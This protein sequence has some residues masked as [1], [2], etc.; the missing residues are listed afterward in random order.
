M[1]KLSSITLHSGQLKVDI[2]VPSNVKLHPAEQTGPV[3]A[4][5]LLRRAMKTPLG[6]PPIEECAVGGDRIVVIVDPETPELP[7]I[8]TE[9]L[10]RLQQIGQGAVT[11]RLL[12]PADP[13]GQQ[14]NRLTATVPEE[15]RQSLIVDIH[16]PADEHQRG[17][18][19]SSAGGE[20]IYLN[21]HLLDA[22][23]IVM[24]STIQFDG[25]LGYRGTCSAVFPAFSDA[26]TIRETRLQGHPELTPDQ[27][28]PMRE[29]VDEIGW[30]LGT[31]FAVQVVPGAD[32]GV[33][34]I[35]AGAPRDVQHASQEQLLQLWKLQFEHLVDL[36]VV[37]VPADSVYGW[38]WF[39][40]AVDTA[41]RLVRQGGRL[42]VI[43]DLQTP[44]TPALQ[45]LRRTQEPED[46]IKPLRREPTEDSV[47]ALQLIQA[48]R[49]VRVYLHSAISAETVEEFGMYSIAGSSE[50]QKLL[51]SANDTA[52][53][54][55]ANFAWC[56]VD[57]EE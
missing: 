54:A 40:N 13:Q 50:L 51:T 17:Y 36:A 38:K 10:R 41:S 45:A 55:G 30:L 21:R 34:A 48:M 42:V 5:E 32:G 2:S 9:V 12:L 1:G 8:L 43:A 31:Q 57:D 16:D 11:L 26:E 14:W 37:S 47:E 35:I 39:G 22:D 28:R 15:I 6:L 23:L 24:I 4:G 49:R 27:K 33:F 18:L 53:I 25:L 56:H 44:E 29:L 46:L 52:V 7:L 20:R 19:A 3:S